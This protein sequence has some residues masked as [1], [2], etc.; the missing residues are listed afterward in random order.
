MISPN[1]GLRFALAAAVA[2]VAAESR[3]QSTCLTTGFSGTTF[4]N[5]LG[6]AALFDMTVNAD[7]AIQ[8]MEAHFNALAGTP[9]T[10][11]IW[12]TPDRRG[13]A[14]GYEQRRFSAA[15]KRGR[16]VLMASPDGRD[17]SLTLNQDAFLYGTIVEDGQHE[18]H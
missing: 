12:I 18:P 3:A 5:T 17:G 15:D 13:V 2:A 6:P 11:Q 1:V 8:S 9:V 4:S 16:V 10:L 14:P 7:I